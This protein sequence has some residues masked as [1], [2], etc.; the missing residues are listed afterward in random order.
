MSPHQEDIWPAF[1]AFKGRA[2]VLYVVADPLVN[3][4]RARIHTLEMAA[5]LPAIYN[6]REFVEAGG[7]ISYGPNF[8]ELARRAADFVGSEARRYTSRATNQ[9]R[10]RYQSDDG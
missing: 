4:N 6:A 9:I 1:Q 5:Q 7:L 2:Q 3:T 10:S 8:L